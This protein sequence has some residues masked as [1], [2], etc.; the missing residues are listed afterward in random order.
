MTIDKSWMHLPRCCLEYI[1]GVESFLN[2]AFQ[3]I[4]EEDMKI[5]C[6]CVNCSN[7]YRMT[8]NEVQCHLLF[9]GIRH[10]YTTWYLHGEDDSH[11]NDSSDEECD[12]DDDVEHG[13]DMIGTIGDIY[14]HM[15]CDGESIGIEPQEPNED[16]KKFY[17]LLEE[18]KQP[19]YPDCEKYSSLSFIVELMHIKCISTWSNNSFNML[20]KLLKD[21]FPMCKTLPTSNYEA[22]KIVDN[23]GLHYERIDV[24]K[25]D[26]MIYY[27]ENLEATHCPVCGLSRWKSNKGDKGNH[28]KISWKVLRYFPLKPRLQRLFMSTKTAEEMRWHHDKRVNDGV[29]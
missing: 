24:C 25:N 21:A 13:D 27:K 2:Y 22:K 3:H 1:N 12:N 4:R 11:K 23:L 10:D 6:P 26:C 28:K 19:L 17:R 9:K 29:L 7:R 18:V 15:M 20:L 8:R 14:P 16:A 5:N